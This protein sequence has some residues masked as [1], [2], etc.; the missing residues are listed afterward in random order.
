MGCVSISSLAAAARDPSL[1][2]LL[3]VYIPGNRVW[4]SDLIVGA[5]FVIGGFLAWSQRMSRSAPAA[6]GAP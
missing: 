5:F 1:I 4:V 6:T 2:R 3:T